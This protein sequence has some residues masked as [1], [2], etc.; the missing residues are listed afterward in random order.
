MVRTQNSLTLQ[1]VEE[2]ANRLTSVMFLLYFI[3]YMSIYTYAPPQ[4]FDSYLKI[5]HFTV[6][7]ITPSGNL[8]RAMFVALNSF[9]TACRDKRFISYPGEISLY[10]GPIL[11]LTL[12]ALILFGVLLWWDSGP[13]LKRFRK[14]FKSTDEEEKQ[15]QEKEISDELYRVNSSSNGLRTLHL[16]KAFGSTV[17]V[18]DVTFGVSKG[19]VFALLGPNGAGKST[20]ISM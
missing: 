13:T 18:E 17:A 15:S 10:G 7:L 19:E 20:T 14:G 2:S 3:G 12:Q 16:T 1:S 9:S 11:Y 5:V 6:A 8:T 4:K